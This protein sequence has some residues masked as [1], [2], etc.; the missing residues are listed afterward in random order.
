[1]DVGKMRYR[2]EV[3]A[4]KSTRDGDGFETREWATLH[5]VWADIV[6]ISGKEYLASSR[7]TSEVTCRIYI[8]YR[9]GIKTTMRIKCKERIFEIESVL[10]DK[11]SGI[12]TIMAKEVE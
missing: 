1:M 3:Q 6:P 5:M 4:Y 7:E 9:P 12:L 10:G 8:R 2:I 11:R